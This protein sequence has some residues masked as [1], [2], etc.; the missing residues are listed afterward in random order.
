MYLSLPVQSFL[1]F[2]FFSFTPLFVVAAEK[3]QLNFFLRPDMYFGF[4]V[5]RDTAH[6][7][8]KRNETSQELNFTDFDHFDWYGSGVGGEIYLGYEKF[9]RTH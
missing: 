7:N 1:L 2:I 9:F 3:T 5:I 6:Y 4:S 8:F